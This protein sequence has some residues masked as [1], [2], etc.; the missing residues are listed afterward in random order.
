MIRAFLVWL[1]HSL[2]IRRSRIRLLALTESQLR[3]IGLTRG[4]IRAEAARPFWDHRFSAFTL[5]A[6]RRYGAVSSRDARN[7]P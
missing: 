6:G 1:R 5:H 7:V 4:Q 2:G 3:D